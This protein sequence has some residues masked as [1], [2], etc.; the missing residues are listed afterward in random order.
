MGAGDYRRRGD[1]RHRHDHRALRGTEGE[2]GEYHRGLT[3]YEF[4]I[5]GL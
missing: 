4:V 5:D 1:L 2:K 3:E